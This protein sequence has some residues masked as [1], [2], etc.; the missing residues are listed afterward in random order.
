MR[1][2]RRKKRSLACVCLVFLLSSAKG[3]VNPTRATNTALS[4]YLSRCSPLLFP[5][6][7]ADLADFQLDAQI[8]GLN[9]MYAIVGRAHGMPLEAVNLGSLDAFA[10]ASHGRV[11]SSGPSA[12]E[13][14][15]HPGTAFASTSD[16]PP[17][18]RPLPGR[19]HSRS[20]QHA[21]CCALLAPGAVSAVHPRTHGS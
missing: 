16:G 20:E 15:M 18:P 14:Q 8:L 3:E 7:A 21:P 10:V 17:S 12:Q 1:S 4:P 13:S 9:P 5:T 2:L 6:L 11:S 19:V